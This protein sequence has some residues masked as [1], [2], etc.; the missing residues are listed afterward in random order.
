MNTYSGE[1][2]ATECTPC[3]DDTYAV[4]GS[5]ECTKRK[6]CTKDD[7][8]SHYTECKV[9]EDGKFVRD[10]IYEWPEYT[11]CDYLSEEAQSLIPANQYNIEC[12]A[13]NPGMERNRTTGKCV[14]C[15]FDTYSDG[16]SGCKSCGSGAR[17]NYGLYINKWSEQSTLD[18]FTT[19]CSGSC[20]EKANGWQLGGEYVTSG[21]NNGQTFVTTL[22]LIFNATEKTKLTVGYRIHKSTDSVEC[23]LVYNDVGIM[24]RTL[25]RSYTDENKILNE[26]F[27]ISEGHHHVRFIFTSVTKSTDDTNYANIYFINIPYAFIVETATTNGVTGGNACASCGQGTYSTGGV[28]TCDL[29]DPGTSSGEGAS[30]CTK[31]PEN[32]FND[33]PGGLCRSCGNNVET[34]AGSLQCPLDCFYTPDNN[35]TFYDIRS[36]FK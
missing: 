15:G 5:T 27:D 33:V 24:S 20:Y 7:Y 19:N 36:L 14:F 4:A 9:S 34:P 29:C 23:A 12:D 17:A 2:G 26:T 10:L 32:T 25:Y 11:K 8:I 28:G 35:K 30:N 6:N 22:E 18:M 16:T 1:D 3:S 31:C 21:V 13:C